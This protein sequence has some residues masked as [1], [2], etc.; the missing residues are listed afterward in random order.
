MG[1]NAIELGP[2]RTIIHLALEVSL[3]AGENSVKRNKSGEII[4]YTV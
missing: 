2:G 3:T 1:G 4:R